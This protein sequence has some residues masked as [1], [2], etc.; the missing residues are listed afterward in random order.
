MVIFANNKIVIVVVSLIKKTDNEK[1][2]KK[3]DNEKFNN[4]IYP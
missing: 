3:T 2:N 1:F 4:K